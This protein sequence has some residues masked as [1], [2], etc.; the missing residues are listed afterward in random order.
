VPPFPLP[1]RMRAG[2]KEAWRDLWHT[3]QAVAWERLGWNRTVGRYCRVMVAAERELD[4]TLLS[5]TRQLEDRLGLTPKA[6]RLM[7]WTIVGDTVAE[8][9]AKAA[10]ERRAERQRQE[11]QSARQ[12]IRAVDSA[13]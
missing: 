1:G 3:P 2:E 6:M 4:S 10:E 7:L 11:A 13:G 8:Q 12:R 9:R 5:E